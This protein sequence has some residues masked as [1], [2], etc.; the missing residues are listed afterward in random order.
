MRNYYD[1][2]RRDLANAV[3]NG[4]RPLA[5]HLTKRAIKLQLELY[6]PVKPKP[7]AGTPFSDSIDFI[8]R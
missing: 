1:R 4:N 3:R 6:G 5:K 8:G 7:D 2:T